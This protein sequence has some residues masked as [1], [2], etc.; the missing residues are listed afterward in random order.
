MLVVMLK[1]RK[2]RMGAEVGPIG[3]ES[4]KM[5]GYMCGGWGL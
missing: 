1:E 2:A 3:G 5:S 4:V